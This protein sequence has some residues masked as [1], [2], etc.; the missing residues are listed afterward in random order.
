MN[1]M[2]AS[3]WTILPL[4][5][6]AL[7]PMGAQSPQKSW[8]LDQEIQGAYPGGLQSSTKLYYR[9][10]LSESGDVLWKTTKIDLGL[11]NA[12][13]PA[14]DFLGAFVD[15]EPIAFFDIALTAQTQGYF[16]ALGYGFHDMAGYQ[17]A[18]DASTLE[19]L[20]SKNALGYC[21]Q[22]APTLKVALGRIAASDTFTISYFSVDD[23]RGYFYEAEANCILAK[24]G[25]ELSNQAYLLFAVREG[26]MLGLNDSL[27]RVPS[28]GYESHLVHAVA[29]FDSAI[30]KGMSL[31]FAML[32]GLYVEDRYFDRQ[33]HL[34]GTVGLALDL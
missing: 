14:F 32:T 12:L 28:S 17:S 30:G 4:C 22:A 34:A 5:F 6:A 11:A 26:F 20:P 18:F 1:A 13:S 8:H 16:R 3:G 33:V 25:V 21:L 29:V 31:Y 9:I 15:I 23:G 24:K 10:P 19:A 27:L 2:R 7:M